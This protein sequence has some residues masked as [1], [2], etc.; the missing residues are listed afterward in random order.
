MEGLEINDVY[1]EE[2]VLSMTYKWTEIPGTCNT[3]IPWAW[4]LLT[5]C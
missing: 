3:Y 4:Q 2:E 5:V 1:M